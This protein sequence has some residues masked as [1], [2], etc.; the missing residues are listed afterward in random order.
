MLLSGLSKARKRLITKGIAQLRDHD[1]ALTNLLDVANLGTTVGPK[2]IVVF[3][4]EPHAFQDP[5]V[6]CID[7]GT[8]ATGN[9]TPNGARKELQDVG[10]RLVVVAIKYNGHND[11]LNHPDLLDKAIS[12]CELAGGERTNTPMY[13]IG[14]ISFYGNDEGLLDDFEGWCTNSYPYVSPLSF[15]DVFAQ[16]FIV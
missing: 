9:W 15:D 3:T 7:V 5:M 1:K 11:G 16:D 4:S 10:P 13:G 14:D 6:H 12:H 2:H 8:G